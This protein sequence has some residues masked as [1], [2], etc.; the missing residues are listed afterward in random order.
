[1]IWPEGKIDVLLEQSTTILHSY[2]HI[3]I[4]IQNMNVGHIHVAKFCSIL[5]CEYY[6]F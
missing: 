2:Q 1:M 4:P 6:L 5:T 3:S